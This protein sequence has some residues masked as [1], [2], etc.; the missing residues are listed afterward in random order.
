MVLLTKLSF[1]PLKRSIGSSK[2]SGS[3]HNLL[4]YILH[5]LIK[6]SLCKALCLIFKPKVI[7]KKLS[8]KKIQK[9]QVSVYKRDPINNPK[10][11]SNSTET[12]IKVYAIEGSEKYK[13]NKMITI[14]NLI[15]NLLKAQLTLILKLKTTFVLLI[16]YAELLSCKFIRLRQDIHRPFTF[17]LFKRSMV[18][19]DNKSQLSIALV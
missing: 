14:N 18:I 13:K 7:K 6:I 17:Y 1:V 10:S 8:R 5:S 16:S 12:E 11:P 19:K 15:S 4:C 2:K 9:F 3:S